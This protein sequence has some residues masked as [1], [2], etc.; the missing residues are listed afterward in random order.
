MH[1]NTDFLKF[2][3]VYRERILLKSYEGKKGLIGSVFSILGFLISLK[4]SGLLQNFGNHF[5]PS[6]GHA[7]Q[8]LR[9]V[10][11]VVNL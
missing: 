5:V 9:L 1:P 6:N 8:S 4:F 3:R 7:F 11:E 2:A 10:L